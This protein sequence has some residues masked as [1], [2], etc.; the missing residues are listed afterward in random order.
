MSLSFL[1][2]FYQS[3]YFPI[4]LLFF[5]LSLSVTQLGGTN[6]KSRFAALRA[7]TEKQTLSI[8]D[9]KEW[10]HDWSL[11]PSGNY[12]SN[13][14]P[15]GVILGL[16]PFALA[17]IPTQ[18]FAKSSD[19]KGRIPEPN[20]GQILFL[21]LL[22]QMIP[23][24]F[25]VHFLAKKIEAKS[26][27]QISFFFV[28]ATL[29]GNTAAIYMN[30]YFGHGLAAILFLSAFF[31]FYEDKFVESSFFIGLSCLTDYSALLFVPFFLIATLFKANRVQ[32]YKNIIIGSTLPMIFFLWYHWQVFGG[33]LELATKYINPEQVSPVPSN[34]GLIYGTSRIALPKWEYFKGLLFSTERG[35][36]F[37]QPWVFF[38]ILIVF[39]K[40]KLAEKTFL[41]GGFLALLLA[42]SSVNYWHG[43]WT[44]GPRYISFVFPAFAYALC[45]NWLP[46]KK[47]LSLFAWISLGVACAFRIWSFPFSNLAPLENLW[48]YFFTQFIEAK[49]ATPYARLAMGLIF[50]AACS[51]WMWRRAK[52]YKASTLL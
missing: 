18:I 5:L 23:F 51:F 30:C 20:Y 15:G 42:I 49:K 16:V 29:F 38:S 26:G 48:G 32:N 19:E 44:I 3:T 17:E 37:T 10:T 45:M 9:Y 14:A 2:N 22:S 27:S 35:I 21:V 4:Y 24:C 34:E 6:A 31:F 39:F 43:G 25:I 50:T 47:I 33:P 11:A 8:N 41:L 7:I 40:A 46:N 12:Y 1:R 13:K 36:L 28:L 52:L